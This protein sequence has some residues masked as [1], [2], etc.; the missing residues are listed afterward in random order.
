MSATLLSG[1]ALAK[2]QRAALQA[3]VS[4][5]VRS[6]GLKPTLAILRVEG[7]EASAGYAR[8]IE[9][10]CAGIGAAFRPQVLPNNATQAE[11]EA[12]L[13]GLNQE[14]TIHGIMILEPLP[15]HA[16]CLGRPPGGNADPG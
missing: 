7:D 5:F 10:S 4:D 1:T 2:E 16:R 11:I 14:H 13:T 6:Y 9:K 15:K 8:A 12:A 3:E